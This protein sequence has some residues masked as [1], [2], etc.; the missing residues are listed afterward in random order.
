MSNTY[1]DTTQTAQAFNPDRSAFLKKI[2]SWIGVWEIVPILAIAA[3]LRFYQL[4]TTE[5]DADQAMVFRMARDAISH[6]LIPATSNIASIRIVNP[7]AVIYL[8]MIPAAISSNPI[9]GAIFVGILN[10]IAVLLTY[11]CVRRYYGRVASIIASLLYA[12]ASGPLHYSRFIWQQNMIAPFV[13]LFIF[14]LYWGVV[15]RRKGWLFP[16]LILLGIMIQLHETTII[17]SLLLL[18]AL[19]LSP[20]TVTVRDL[21]LGFIFLLLLFSSYILWEFSIKFADLSLLLQMLKIHSHIDLTALNDYMLFLNP[22]GNLPTNAHTL[23]YKLIPLLGWLIPIMAL[24]IV[25]GFASIIMG[26]ISSPHVWK[27]ADIVVEEST[28]TH[29]TLRRTLHTVSALLTDFRAAPQRCGYF[30]LLCWQIVPILIF[31]AM[32]RPSFHIIY[33]WSCQGLLSSSGFYSPH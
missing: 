26:V 8:L 30:L 32:L 7:P 22:Y 16:A 10:I 6:G 4:T 14:A 21:V 20:G 1:F 33:S 15:D 28:G 2:G 27:S 12:T 25:L 5:F 11:I 17:L 18:V 24:L 13:V 31:H 23:E 3:F 19:M 9:G 29:H